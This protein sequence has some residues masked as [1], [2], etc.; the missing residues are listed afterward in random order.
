M[1]A[2][3]A[4]LAAAAVLGGCSTSAKQ[5]E[6]SAPSLAASTLQQDL[7]DRL[8][9]DGDAPKSVTCS[10]ELAGQVGAVATCAVVTSDNAAVDAVLNVTAV[11][12]DAVD[13]DVQPRLS[14]DQ[15]EKAVKALT[16]ADSVACDSGIEGKTGQIAD[17]TITK[18][19]NVAQ[20][21][22][23]VNNVDGLKVDLAVN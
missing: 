20:N 9:K 16:S 17:C 4:M 15:L 10:G 21:I 8:T 7:T 3:A 5:S 12:G 1:A 18:G 19:G 14:R 22:V 6:S 23:A 2:G 11:N 13:Y